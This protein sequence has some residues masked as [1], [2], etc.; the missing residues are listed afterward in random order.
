MQLSIHKPLE[1]SSKLTK[2]WETELATAL[3]IQFYKTN[4]ID[5]KFNTVLWKQSSG[6]EHNPYIITTFEM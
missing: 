3:N 5:A 1:V 4:Q 6:S 2:W